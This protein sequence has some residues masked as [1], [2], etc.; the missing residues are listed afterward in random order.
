MAFDLIR[1]ITHYT[2]IIIRGKKKIVKHI[3]VLLL[4]LSPVDGGGREFLNPC[5]LYI[6]AG[7]Q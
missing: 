7:A 4:Y 6:A 5:F 1:V 2:K 3:L